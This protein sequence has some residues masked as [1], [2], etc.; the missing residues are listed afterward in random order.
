MIGTSK[1]A[2]SSVESSKGQD[3]PS[4]SQARQSA[5][6]IKERSAVRIGH[7]V[8]HFRFKWAEELQC[9]MGV[10][11]RRWYLETPFGSIRVHHWLHSDDDRAFHDHPWW[12][13]TLV[14]RG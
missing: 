8:P 4:T 5:L 14:L 2:V 7:R 6:R 9:K 1:Y 13:W 3:H 12:F 10:Y 11:V